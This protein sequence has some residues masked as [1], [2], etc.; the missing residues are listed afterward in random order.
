MLTAIGESSLNVQLYLAK[1]L[2]V[3]VDLIQPYFTIISFGT[4][5]D[6]RVTFEA[7]WVDVNLNYRRQTDFK[8]LR[9]TYGKLALSLHYWPSGEDVWDKIV[10]PYSLNIV[11]LREI[12]EYTYGYEFPKHITSTSEVISDA[13]YVIVNTNDNRNHARLVVRKS[14]ENKWKLLPSS[15]VEI[16]RAR[17]PGIYEN[18]EPR[19]GFS[20]PED[21]KSKDLVNNQKKMI[22]DAI[23]MVKEQ[24]SKAKTG[25]LI[26][27]NVGAGTNKNQSSAANNQGKKITL[28]KWTEQPKVEESPEEAKKSSD[29]I[30]DEK[31]DEEGKDKTTSKEQ[32]T[33]YNT[34]EI[35]KDVRDHLSELMHV[36]G[37]EKKKY[38]KPYPH[39]N[40]RTISTAYHNKAIYDCAGN[41]VD[42]AAKRPNMNTPK[43]P[44]GC[45]II[46]T[47]PRLMALDIEYVAKNKDV[48]FRNL[49]AIEAAE[50]FPEYN[51]VLTDV[52]YYLDDA[53][54]SNFVDKALDKGDASI[55]VNYISYPNKPGIY[56][57]IAKEGHAIVD[58][59]GIVTSKVRGN[60]NAYVHKVVSLETGV[61]NVFNSKKKVS[62]S[63]EACFEIGHGMHYEYVVIRQI[64]SK[65]KGPQPTTTLTLEARME[66]SVLPMTEVQRRY[67][68]TRQELLCHKK[69][70]IKVNYKYQM[71]YLDANFRPLLAIKSSGIDDLVR[72]Y[73]HSVRLFRKT[74][75]ESDEIYSGERLG[76][77]ALQCY[78]E[79]D[80]CSNYMK[81]YKPID[82]EPKTLWNIAKEAVVGIACAKLANVV[83]TKV[84]PKFFAAAAPESNNTYKALKFGAKVLSFGI[85][86]GVLYTA[87]KAAEAYEDRVHAVVGKKSDPKLSPIDT[88]VGAVV[89][90]YKDAKKEAE[91]VAGMI[92]DSIQRAKEFVSD[93]DERARTELQAQGLKELAADMSVIDEIIAED[94]KK[95]NHVVESNNSIEHRSL[96][97]FAIDADR[98]YANETQP[99]E[100][101]V[102]PNQLE[103]AF[104]YTSIPN[105]WSTLTTAIEDR[106]VGYVAQMFPSALSLIDEQEAEDMEQVIATQRDF[107]AIDHVIE[108]SLLDNWWNQPTE[109][110]R[111]GQLRSGMVDRDDN[112]I[113]VIECRTP[114]VEVAQNNS[115]NNLEVGCAAT[116]K[117]KRK[118]RSKNV[119]AIKKARKQEIAKSKAGLSELESQHYNLDEADRRV[120]DYDSAVMSCDISK[121]KL[122]C[123]CKPMYYKLD[124]T[125][126]LHFGSCALNTV[127]ALRMRQASVLEFPHKETVKDF[128]L[129]VKD[130]IDERDDK[131]FCWIVENSP[132]YRLEDYFE[133]LDPVHRKLYRSGYEKL[134]E[135]AR[136]DCKLGVFSKTNEIHVEKDARPRCLFNPSDE[137]K[138]VGSFIA[139]FFIKLMKQEFMFGTSF[140][141]GYNEDQLCKII[142][143]DTLYYD[144]NNFMSY[145]GSSHDAHQH[146]ELLE[147]VDNGF[148][149]RYLMLFLGFSEFEPYL[150]Q[151]IYNCLTATK[152]IFESS[153]GLTGMLRGTVFSGHPTRTT[154]FNTTR[155]LL[156]NHYVC[157]RLG[158][159]E[160]KI[161]ASGDDVLCI[162]K[163]PISKDDY[164][165]ILG[166]PE[167]AAGLGQLAKDFVT[168]PLQKHSFLSRNFLSMCPLVMN[169]D[170]ARVRKTGIVMPMGLAMTTDEY[171]AVVQYSLDTEMPGSTELYKRAA[172]S[173]GKFTRPAPL[174]AARRAL[175]W[176]EYEYVLRAQPLP[177]K[178][179]NLR[180]VL[181]SSVGSDRA[182]VMR[183]ANS[184]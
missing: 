33:L 134:K 146:E 21:K 29:E 114:N 107:A 101:V 64:D 75:P 93:P 165:S 77:Y 50:A 160:R 167:R 105:T 153:F 152:T 42:H 70:N 126:V 81:S 164:K 6:P 40:L 48:T 65:Y 103:T 182:S 129:Y 87:K 45:E 88:V 15:K 91:S 118:Q 39:P 59:N 181:S 183:L 58:E 35:T 73:D 41:V 173:G 179:R 170:P 180:Y 137:M 14:V 151:E 44:Q 121:A 19:E 123:S 8:G 82:A 140:V 130:F 60:P 83:L 89:T 79:S 127:A 162:F 175:G 169:R 7:D 113:A 5:S 12:M 74:C 147:I 120:A 97:G 124:N 52:V 56:H 142:E 2:K 106:P 27:S 61:Y 30:K 119:A 84:A 46:R 34:F 128:A 72:S 184:F 23:D 11:Y 38:T 133:S 69:S 168:G 3:D 174:G 16:K 102:I 144:H 138:F 47:R 54:W 71:P 1:G 55:R 132:D 158:I 156:Y 154:L 20:K 63:R 31:K 68:S 17:I 141:S 10:K 149:S 26:D 51:H 161:Y 92:T 13:V 24:K 148:F 155:V 159:G 99:A 67:Y 171:K 109:L 108:E 110:L 136:I 135:R 116:V 62:V 176:S 172:D 157:D 57:Y 95:P 80:E 25:D 143:Q 166:V 43:S 96:I 28:T 112:A 22:Q 78:L 98:V 125:D 131:I 178:N 49:T 117:R 122:E 18:L 85:G 76:A 53:Q 94:N 9:D 32:Y 111:S 100:T 36:E 66:Y 163:E 104:N 4:K 139:R 145:D 37:G 86:V 150:H 177:E 90:C 115:N